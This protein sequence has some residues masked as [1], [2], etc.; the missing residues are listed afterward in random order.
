MRIEAEMP[1]WRA[2]LSWLEQRADAEHLLLLAATTWHAFWERGNVREVRDWLDQALVLPG[3]VSTDSRALALAIAA[4]SAWNQGDNDAAERLALAALELS[5]N[6]RL[7][8]RT[9]QALYILMLVHQ[10][11]GDFAR[12]VVLGGDAIHHFRR[13]ENRAWLPQALV[14][15]GFNASLGG[16]LERAAAFREE[17]LAL[18]R[19]VGSA[20]TV[21]VA[22]SDMGVEAE[23]RGGMQTALDQYRESLSL[24]LDICDETYIAHPLAGMASLA[25]A[26]GKMDLAARLLGVVAHV[27][28]T[29]GTVA[30]SQERERDERTASVARSSLGEAGYNQAFTAGRHLAVAEAAREALDAVREWEPKEA[31]A[32][33]FTVAEEAAAGSPGGFSRS[34]P[35][36]P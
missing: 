4:L 34:K 10:E 31:K 9:A 3:P 36:Q 25:S 33:A 1:N 26:S 24:L 30:F 32:G 11:R 15:T 35:S 22:L 2:A 7:T 28:E 14:D 20:W 6:D 13:A 21:A 27:H 17:G 5:Q 8:L 18:A 19:E 16:D 29:R 12:G 23:A